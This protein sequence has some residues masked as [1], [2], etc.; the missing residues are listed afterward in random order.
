MVITDWK[1]KNP[2]NPL[3]L[4]LMIYPTVFSLLTF[5]ESMNQRVLMLHLSHVVH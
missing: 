4:Y 2:Q 3:G 5:G 1:G